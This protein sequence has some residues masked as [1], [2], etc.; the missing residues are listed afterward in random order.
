MNNS[1]DPKEVSIIK[2]MLI[3]Q[4]A[5]NNQE[6]LSYFTRPGHDI[7]HARISEIKGGLTWSW[8][9]PAPVSVTL[10]YMNARASLPYPA[11]SYFLRG[12]APTLARGRTIAALQITCW[13][14]GQGLF[15]SG[16]L[17]STAGGDF[18]WVYDCGSSSAASV[19]R[20]AITVFQAENRQRFIDLV[21]LSHFDEDH[22][23]GIVELIRGTHIGILL[24]PYLPLW[25]RLH[26]A[27]TEGITAA[28]PLFEFFVDPV[29]YLAERAEIDEI[30]FVPPAGPDDVASGAGEEPDPERPIEGAKVEDDEL[31]EDVADDPALSGRGSTAVRA[32]KRGGRIVVPSLWEFVPYNDVNMQP[33]VT[34]RFELWTRRLSNI[35]IHDFAR[36]DQVLRIL[37]KVYDRTFGGTSKPRNLI[38]L[39]LYS[40]PVGA[41]VTLSQAFASHPVRW[42]SA[43]DN[44]AQLST[45]DGYLNSVARL[46]ALRR[47]Y[48]RNRRLDRAGILQVMHHGA[49]GNWHEGVGA[50]LAPAVSLFSSDPGNKK[51]RHPHASVLR[52]FWSYCPV[53]IDAANTFRLHAIL[54]LP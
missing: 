40:G 3:L 24:L 21:T 7:N 1:L 39:F 8:V 37:K 49:E 43:R 29:G 30:V 45:G 52:D 2:R 44:F 42:N 41:R 33:R 15:M 5:L 20:K 51:L 36:R 6:I 10:A 31:P 25:Q 17:S 46:D 11:V 18:S 26:V 23:N 16:R 54:A 28:N 27:M 13:P 14:V 53:Q 50:A 19:L 12:G 35:L 22:I 47:F 4:P 48:G 34:P 38:S 9:R 32:L